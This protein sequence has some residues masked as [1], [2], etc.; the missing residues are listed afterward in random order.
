VLWRQ[1]GEVLVLAHPDREDA[2]LAVI[3]PAAAVWLLFATAPDGSATEPELAG[4]LREV[5]EVDDATA[6]RAVAEVVGSLEHDG[7][8]ERVP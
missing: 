3:G 6:S 1:S 8:L 4:G 2:P 5:F 7:F